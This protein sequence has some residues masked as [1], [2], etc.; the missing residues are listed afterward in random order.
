[1]NPLI[2]KGN[3]IYITPK[4]YNLSVCLHA[5]IITCALPLQRSHAHTSPELSTG[6]EAGYTGVQQEQEPGG[7]QGGEGERAARVGLPQEPTRLGPAG[8]GAPGL[9]HRQR[10]RRYMR[11]SRHFFHRG[12]RVSPRPIFGNFTV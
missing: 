8:P 3:G 6:E 7:G 9:R 10:E 1:M 5:V 11:E 12:W 2:R 4:T